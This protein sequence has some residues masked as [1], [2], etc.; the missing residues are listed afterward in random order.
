ML[1]GYILVI[2]AAGIDTKGHALAPLQKGT[3]NP[4]KIKSSSGGVARNISENLVRLG[5]EA[6]LLSAVGDDRSG[7]RI[8]NRLN[9]VG[10]DTGYIGDLQ[11][12]NPIFPDANYRT[13][14]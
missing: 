14:L 8:L 4:G 10:V 2:G 1:D 6:V 5:E 9:D 11:R 12:L 13:Y 3:S 7:L